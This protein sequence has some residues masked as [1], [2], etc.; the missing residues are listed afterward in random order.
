MSSLVGLTLL[1]CLALAGQT[2]AD[3]VIEN[4]TLHDG[5]GGPPRVGSLA[6]QGERIV[7]VGEFTVTGSPRRIDGAGLIAAP[8]FID[9]HTHCDGVTRDGARLNK[10][11]LMQGVTTVVTG[12]CGGGR[13]DVD[14]YL[15][16]V[17]ESGTGTNVVH[18]IPHG[19]LR[20]SVV[21]RVNRPPT[22]D[23]LA[24]MKQRIAEHMQAGAWG[25]STG[26]IYTPGSFAKTDELVELARTVHEHQ[27][28]YASHIRNEGIEL[29]EAVEE[30][31]TIGQ[32]AGLP[33]HISHFKASGE[34]AW[35][36]ASRAIQRIEQARSAGTRATADQYPYIASSTSL[37]AMVVPQAQRG[38]AQLKA[39]MADPEKT[40]E[41][42]AAIAKGLK[43]RNGGRS[44]RVASYAKQRAWHGK[45]LAS[46]A[47]EKGVDIIDL[48][49]EIEL[50]G[51]AKMVSFGMQEEE[52]RL[53]MQ[54]PFVATA[55]DGGVQTPGD[56]VPH[57]RS[58][59]CF[60]RKIGR[61]A[62]EEAVISLEQAIHSATGL[63]AEILCLARRGY[64]RPQ[65]FADIVVFDP[66]T[67]RDTA[68]FDE[69]HQYAIGVRYLFVNGRLA[70]D[71]GRV[72]E[73]R[74]GRAL[75]H[76]DPQER[77]MN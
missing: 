63:P 68:T 72:T 14:K 19:S 24:H 54:Q 10:N 64:L 67:F 18:L 43:S 49:L 29:L 77:A 21:G 46:I 6:V 26:L 33:V 51:G 65:Y 37:S 7:G 42:R 38:T 48:V 25:M 57:P 2:D 74:A 41:L 39:A 70:I 4:V 34:A 5:T 22:E 20:G 28:I 55:S 1:G 11:Y 52:V 17:D 71:D 62:L 47:D 66:A 73:V 8:G 32:L 61:Y 56:T 50:N 35:G 59:G 45:D 27:G 16:E 30:A 76:Q 58:Y 36:L 23:E 44:M 3:V 9:L 15:G 60:P 53:I 75:R 13:L 40:A 31:L 12:N 69:P